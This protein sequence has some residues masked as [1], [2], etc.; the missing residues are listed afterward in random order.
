MTTNLFNRGNTNA[1]KT[2]I[3]KYLPQYT[4]GE[5]HETVV[6]CPIQNV[7]D[8]A[9]DF[10]LS[11]SKLIKFLFRLRGLPTKRMRLQ[12][13]IV[14]IG[15]TYLEENPPYENLTGFWMRPRI[16]RIPSYEDFLNDSISSRVKVVWNFRFEEMEEN[17]TKVSTETRILCVV[18]ITKLTFGLYW[19]MVKPFSGLIRKEMLNIIKDGSEALKLNG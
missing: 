5:H 18:P 9:R 4:F 3:D 1:K 7:Y 19:T 15:F 2:L 8:V 14:D 10:D 6:N 11:K 13:F 12:D 16:E 17:K